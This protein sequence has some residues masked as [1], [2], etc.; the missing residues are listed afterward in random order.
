M[1]STGD[2]S[3]ADIAALPTDEVALLLEISTTAFLRLDRR[4]VITYVNAQAEALLG[5]SRNALVGRDIWVEFPTSN[6]D[7]RMHYETAVE[8]RQEVTFEAHFA[9]LGAWFEIR[10]APDPLGLSIFY[11]DVTERH[12]IQDRLAFVEDL[13]R[14]L[15]GN[16]DTDA[17]AAVVA[18]SVVPELATWALISLYDE[19]G[20]LYEA[21]AHHRDGAREPDIRLLEQAHPQLISDFEILTAT[22][23]GGAAQVRAGLAALISSRGAAGDPLFQLLDRLGCDSAVLLP[24]TARGQAFGIL[25]LFR[26]ETDAPYSDEELE[27]AG[28][29]ADRA[30]LG[31][32]NALL[33]SRLR[34][35]A[36]VLQRS[37]LTPLPQPAS[38]HLVG[39]YLP[40]AVGTEVG[41]DWYDA[42]LQPDGATVLVI[43]DIVGH[44][45]AAAAAMGQVRNLLRGTAYD[46]GDG[47]AELMLR[48]DGLIAGLGIDTLATLLIGRLEQDVGQRERG[49]RTFRWSNAGHAPPMMRRPGGEVETLDRETDL[50]LGLETAASRHEHSVTM[51]AGDTLFLYTDGLIERRDR[52]LTDGLAELADTLARVD[53]DPLD[54]AC[55]RLLG[56]LLTDR[57]FDDVAL[58]AVH[59]LR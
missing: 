34:R 59:A 18:R 35:T 24:L 15:V 52:S 36:E 21:A 30:A 6:T 32:E 50:L 56:L 44:D 10:C 28:I 40:A 12:R 11:L 46:R 31:L 58:L 43:G 57:P 16:R 37:L 19:E 20:R 42:F 49:E 8:T 33:Y 47:P 53:M 13:T 3:E 29:V 39:R 22:T 27:T 2:A 54:A 26:A 7:F 17:V 14:G 5:R 1:S 38:L 55:D 45:I 41:G 25:S 51:R 48:L 9:H 4:W 23:T